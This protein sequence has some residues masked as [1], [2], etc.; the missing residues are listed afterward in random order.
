MYG[1]TSIAQNGNGM[2]IKMAL[3]TF[4]QQDVSRTSRFPDNTFAGQSFFRTD[5]FR[6]SYTKELGI[7]MY[8]CVNTSS[9]GL[10][11]RYVGIRSVY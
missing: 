1:K 4:P 5:V 11:T 10:G 9:I 6:T 3:Q 2:G 7:F 8:M